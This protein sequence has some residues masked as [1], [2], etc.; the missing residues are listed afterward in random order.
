M[1]TLT[2]NDGTVISGY[3]YEANGILWM[4]MHNTTLTIAFNILNAQAKTM[5]ITEIR[6]G[7]QTEYT[8]FSHLFCITEENDG[9]IS[10]GLKHQ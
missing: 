5:K 6:N 8:G 7:V 9:V 4:Y 3:C 10:A 1:E 2:F